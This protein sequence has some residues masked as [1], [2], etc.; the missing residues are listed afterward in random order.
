MEIASFYKKYKCVLVLDV[1]FALLLSAE[2]ALLVVNRS[3][4]KITPAFTSLVLDTLFAF[5]IFRPMLNNIPF[6]KSSVISIC[7]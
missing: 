5:L 4:Y 2:C 6:C 3:V 1:F 7:A